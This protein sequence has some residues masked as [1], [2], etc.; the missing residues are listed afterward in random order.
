MCTF[1]SQ[2]DSDDD[3]EA[4]PYDLWLTKKVADADFWF[5]K[6]GKFLKFTPFC[7]IIYLKETASL[8]YVTL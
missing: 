7:K 2:V 5:L 8:Y 1:S 3:K 6:T 4:I